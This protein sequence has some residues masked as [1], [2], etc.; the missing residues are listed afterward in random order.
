MRTAF[1]SVNIIG[2]AENIFAESVIVLHAQFNFDII[3]GFRQINYFGRKNL[4]VL[5][6]HSNKFA[7]SA[8]IIKNLFADT[9]IFI[10]ALIGQ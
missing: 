6:E 1:N 4:L 2:I 7:N 9:V 8:F 5:I 10:A 3:F